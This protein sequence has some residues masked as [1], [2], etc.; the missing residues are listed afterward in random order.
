MEDD[1]GLELPLL[2]DTHNADSTANTVAPSNDMLHVHD[3][4]LQLVRES[5]I[6][7][8]AKEAGI[9][10]NGEIPDLRDYVARKHYTQDP[11][12]ISHR[13]APTDR[14][15]SSIAQAKESSHQ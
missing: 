6:E 1:F 11:P 15:R 14:F 13:S 8:I 5:G 3:E 12:D 4:F 7:S 2:L 9:V 10:Q